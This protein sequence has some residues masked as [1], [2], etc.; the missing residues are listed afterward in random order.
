L[1][2]LLLRVNEWLSA[3]SLID[4][5]WG[6][7][8]PATA[9]KTL[10]VHVSGLRKALGAGPS[11]AS[12]GLV[13]TREHGYELRLDPDRLD[14]CRFERLVAEGRSELDAGRPER[15]VRALEV[16][17]SLWR[18]VPLGEL[19]SEPFARQEVARLEDRRV[20]ALEQVIEAKLALGGHDEVV[21]PLESL[22][23]E[24]PYRERPRAQLMLALYRSDRQADALHAYQNARKTLV[25]ELGIE[26]G[27]RCAI[28][29]RRS[30]ARTRG[31]TS[32]LPRKRPSGHRRAGCSLAARAS[33]RPST[34]SSATL[35][36]AATIGRRADARRHLEDALAMHARIGARRW[37]ARTEREAARLLGPR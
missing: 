8:P 2:L 27:R 10:Q 35:S 19:S 24:Y 36:L 6:E 34:T 1:A 17:L 15:G 5:L 13:V 30:S 14:A 33:S 18:G 9:S 22:I 7:R 23:S 21:G 29:T 31:S 20:A 28:C 37:H 16:A 11:N 26:P 3:D 12:A 4:A 32:P 25:E